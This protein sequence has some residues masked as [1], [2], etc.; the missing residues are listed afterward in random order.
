MRASD[1][2]ETMGLKDQVVIV[3]GAG[4]GIGRATAL[5][6][7]RLGARVIVNDYGGDSLGHEGDISR[8]QA[9]A[10]E[11]RAAGGQATA[12]AE[13]V[14]S[15]AAAAK[16][17]DMALAAYGRIDALIN[18]AGIMA[19]GEI[20]Q[21]SD[22]LIERVI[23]VN[24]LGPYRLVRAVWPVM[25][26]QGYGRIVNVSSSSLLGFGDRAPYGASKAALIGLTADAAINGKPY[27]ILVNSLLPAAI[28]R[29]T[30]GQAG[31]TEAID[32][33]MWDMLRANFKPEFVAP[34]AAYLVS[35]EL[36]I[37]GEHIV[38]GANRVAKLAHFETAG[39]RAPGLTVDDIAA[40]IATI[41]DTATGAFVASGP[42]ELAQ[43]MPNGG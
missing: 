16:L 32:P 38:A 14:G 18:N 8:A 31:G 2:G 13:A 4:G 37:S 35:P 29:L 26:A 5:L 17:R 39:W 10:G 36:D 3:T 41:R 40:N 27:G 6:L 33:A 22:P 30:D 19:I 12:N 34:A 11:I 43:F 28:T 9:V 23:E 15:V 20:D 1:K 25:K 24:F 21:M 42:Q 7:G